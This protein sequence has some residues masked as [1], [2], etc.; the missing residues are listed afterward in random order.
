M[1]E[2][3]EKIFKSIDALREIISRIFEN[4]F[5]GIIL[6]SFFLSKISETQMLG[7]SFV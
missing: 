5:V 3:K 7:N 4:V 2:L 6:Y 1:K